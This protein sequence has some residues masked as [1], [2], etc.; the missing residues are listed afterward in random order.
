MGSVVEITLMTCN[1]FNQAFSMSLSMTSRVNSITWKCRVLKS[2]C[3][4]QEHPLDR[5][6]RPVGGMERRW[7]PVPA[8]DNTEVYVAEGA[9]N[10][11]TPI[12][13]P[14][15][16]PLGP[17]TQPDFRTARDSNRDEEEAQ[18]LY[19]EWVRGDPNHT[20]ALVLLGLALMTAG[21]WGQISSFLAALLAPSWAKFCTLIALGCFG[22]AIYPWLRPVHGHVK[23]RRKGL[24]EQLQVCTDPAFD[25]YGR[26]EVA[27]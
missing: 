2:E 1:S 18:N 5:V 14:K 26:T 20:A 3:R 19:E 9:P 6:N 4:V 11:R 27:R 25:L 16:S 21:F 22:A 15:R 12:D 17:G 23:E 10:D 13:S 7:K 8:G 24:N